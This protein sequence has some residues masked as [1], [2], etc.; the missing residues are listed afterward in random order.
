MSQKTDLQSNNTDLQT[1]L[2]TIN[3]LPEAG[4]GGGG[5]EVISIN[6]IYKDVAASIYYWNADNQLVSTE[7]TGI[8]ETHSG[9]VQIYHSVGVRIDAT[10]DYTTEM[11]TIGDYY[12]DCFKFT[13]EG[14]LSII[15][16]QSGGSN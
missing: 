8:I 3:N 16:V 10:G 11:V 9:F 2:N 5:N 1:I 15:F 4:S 14:T 12:C 6:I 13:T 7:S